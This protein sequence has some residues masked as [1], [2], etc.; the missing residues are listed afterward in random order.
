MAQRSPL[1][2]LT[3][4]TAVHLPP[5]QQ[6]RWRQLH[7]ATSA[8]TRRCA[9]TCCGRMPTWPARRWW[10]TARGSIWAVGGCRRQSGAGAYLRGSSGDTRTPAPGPAA[11][12]QPR[13]PQRARRAYT[14]H[15]AHL[16]M[17]ES[18]GILVG[19]RQRAARPAGGA[20]AAWMV[21]AAAVLVCAAPGPAHTRL[22][23][24][25]GRRSRQR[26]DNCRDAA[27]R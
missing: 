2:N 4:P 12:L 21:G 19:G 27:S 18:N 20:G 23:P 17:D 26:S 24:A 10:R 9:G 14:G 6:P 16:A 13:L 11:S 8:R 3:P 5:P 15:R 22:A 7:G 25:A 1:V